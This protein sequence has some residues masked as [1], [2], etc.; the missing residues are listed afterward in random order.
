MLA[1][2]AVLFEPILIHIPFSYADEN[3]ATPA[4]TSTSTPSLSEFDSICGDVMS[5]QNSNTPGTP[6]TQKLQYCQSAKSSIH[7]TD[8][9]SSM[10]KVWAAV[11]GVCAAACAASFAG[12][13]NQYICIG[14]TLA[15]AAADAVIT[16]NFMSAMMGVG[17]A[18]GGFMINQMS[19]SSTEGAK[20]RDYG[21]CMSAAVSAFQAY[22]KY[23]SMKTNEKSAKNNLKLAQNVS[24]ANGNAVGSAPIT[25]VV[26]AGGTGGDTSGVGGGSVGSTTSATSGSSSLSPQATCAS[27]KSTAAVGLM[28][29]C[30]VASDSTLP[31]FV[32]S[33]KFQE[34]F[35]RDSGID[36]KD[37]FAKDDPPGKM[38]GSAMGGTLSSA[39][40][41]RLTGALKS[42][43]AYLYKDNMT[44]TYSSGGG[45]GLN[46]GKSEE[47]SIE[48]MMA[49]MMQQFMP[50]A[51][52]D[53]NPNSGLTSVIFANQNKSPTALT[54]DTT[55]NIFDR[56]GYRYYFVGPRMF[57]EGPQP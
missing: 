38:L 4:A 51:E 47:P 9:D 28:I 21:A 6:A 17:A 42:M 52:G 13:G 46:G 15:G 11:G 54:E 41:A 45:G 7:A 27:A 56:V 24:D 53:P 30:A 49:G 37:F 8:A 48:A 34:E 18:G 35:K 14:V 55:L 16:K 40:S 20:Q 22:T 25:S 3:T 43:E 31:K 12:V 29:Q 2:S 1:I 23:S 26:S 33:P 50:K 57:S 44:Q 36:M 5:D 32:S 19:K 39:Q 10:W